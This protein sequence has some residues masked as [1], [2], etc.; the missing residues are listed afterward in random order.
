MLVHWLLSWILHLHRSLTLLTILNI[1]NPNNITWIFNL[2]HFILILV[3]KEF[4]TFRIMTRIITLTLVVNMM[5][6]L[7]S[8]LI[9]TPLRYHRLL[10]QHILDF[11]QFF[12]HLVHLHLLSLTLFLQPIYFIF[13]VLVSWLS[14]IRFNHVT[15][16]GNTEHLVLLIAKLFSLLFT[17]LFNPLLL[18]TKKVPFS[19]ILLFFLKNHILHK[20][21]LFVSKFHCI[22]II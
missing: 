14:T 11:K 10:L 18:L 5:I 21:L 12:L 1:L 3:R 16:V 17:E 15:T 19:M 13:V 20:L 2:L 7:V 22:S 9:V 4:L 6:V 8:S